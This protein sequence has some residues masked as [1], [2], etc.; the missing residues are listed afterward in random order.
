[1]KSVRVLINALFVIYWGAVSL[2]FHSPYVNDKLNKLGVLGLS[3]FC[4]AAAFTLLILVMRSNFHASK[5]ND[6]LAKKR[7]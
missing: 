4:E 2:A 3:A 6:E 7:L 1:M 5:L